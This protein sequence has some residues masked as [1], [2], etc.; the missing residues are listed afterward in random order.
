MSTASRGARGIFKAH[1]AVGLATGGL[2]GLEVQD[3]IASGA[4]EAALVPDLVEAVE[5]LGDVHRLAAL[6]ALGV[7]H[8]ANELVAA[9]E[10][11]WRRST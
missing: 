5:L 7:R 6:S 1:L 10:A 4:A 9:R 8:T 3:L 11:L 2:V